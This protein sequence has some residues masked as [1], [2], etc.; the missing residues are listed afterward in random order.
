MKKLIRISMSALCAFFSM[1][2][3]AQ[4]ITTIAG[5]GTAG[6]SGDGIAATAAEFNNPYGITIDAKGNI[7]VA[8]WTNNRVRK[9]DKITGNISTFAGNG[10]AGFSGDGTPA[11]GASLYTPAGL[12]VDKIGNVYITDRTNS[13]IRKVDTFGII[14]TF[15]GNGTLSFSGDSG[16]AT[17][18]TIFAPMDVACDRH[19]NIYIADYNNNRLRKVDALGIITTLTGSDTFGFKGDGGPASADSVKFYGITGVKVDSAG[20]IYVTDFFNKRIRKIDTAGMLSTFAGSGSATSDGDGGPATDAGIGGVYNMAIRGDGTFFIPEAGGDRIRKIDPSGIIST[21]AG[22]GTVGFGGDNGPATAA[23]FSLPTCVVLDPLGDL[24]IA[25]QDNNRIRKIS[26]SATTGT[27]TINNHV[28]SFDIYPNPNNGNFYV[29]LGS[30]LSSQVD[31][32]I[33]DMSGAE[34]KRINST[35]NVRTFIGLNEA[36]GVYM[37]SAI[38]NGTLFNKK[39]EIIR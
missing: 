17:N 25:D 4:T 30:D 38:M 33:Y 18:A 32:V 2:L 9:I 36:P 24:F 37:V 34:I 3:N 1:A 15:A 35:T 27:A 7:Y 14:T 28:T 16:Q 22:T 29:A 11:T 23:L 19:G 5:N 31:V 26:F 13:R 8:D 20:N 10:T 6:Y 12:A 21:Y 39:I